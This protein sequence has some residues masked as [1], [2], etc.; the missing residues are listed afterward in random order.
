MCECRYC[1][2]QRGDDI[3]VPIEKVKCKYCNIEFEMEV[4]EEWMCP[5]CEHI[6]DKEESE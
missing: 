4:D 6:N 5:A 3:N 2:I 1:R